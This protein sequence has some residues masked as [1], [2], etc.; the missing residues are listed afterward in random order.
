MPIHSCSVAVKDTDGPSSDS[1]MD[2]CAQLSHLDGTEVPNPAF[3]AQGDVQALPLLAAAVEEA[4]QL[5]SVAV[6]DGGAELSHLD[7]E[8][9]PDPTG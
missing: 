3:E 9:R 7:K 8:E 4:D 6:L 1:V 2:G 5:S